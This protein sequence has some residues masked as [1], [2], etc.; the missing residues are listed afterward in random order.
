MRIRGTTDSQ[1][2]RASVRREGIR[3]DK[4]LAELAKVHDVHP[5]QI[6]EWMSQMIERAAS[7]FGTD[8]AAELDRYVLWVHAAS[9]TSSIPIFWV[10]SE[11]SLHRWRRWQ[12]LP[13]QGERRPC[14]SNAPTDLG[15]RLLDQHCPARAP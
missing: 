1:R 15:W 3:G 7:V 5:N 12:R 10:S 4:T 13:Q 14:S 8:A 6:T 2:R 11:Q 9:T